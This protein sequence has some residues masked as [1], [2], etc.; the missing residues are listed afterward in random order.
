MGSMVYG[1][2]LTGVLAIGWGAAGTLGG[3]NVGEGVAGAFV[4]AGGGGA[5]I[6]VGAGGV[7]VGAGVGTGA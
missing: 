5:G 2:L 6:V 3:M 1:G 4:T 7:A